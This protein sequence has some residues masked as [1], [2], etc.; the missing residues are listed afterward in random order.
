MQPVDTGGPVVGRAVLEAGRS[1]ATR[2]SAAND[3]GFVVGDPK[4]HKL[5]GGGKA[6][7]RAG[8]LVI[9][10][11]A[12]GVCFYQLSVV[13]AARRDLVPT[14]GRGGKASRFVG[15]RGSCCFVRIDWVR[16]ANRRRGLRIFQRPLAHFA[17]A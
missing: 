5:T 2:W 12:C 6:G 3:S 1:S 13:L 17:G 8:Q 7:V 10:N 4:K 9:R 15:P 14:D 11:V 16:P